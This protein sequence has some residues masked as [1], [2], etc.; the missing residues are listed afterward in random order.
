MQT[1]I[2]HDELARFCARALEAR[3]MTSADARTVA[4]VLAWAD[5][6]GIDSH[7]I[8][9]LPRYVQFMDD[10]AIDPAAQP[11]VERPGPGR[12]TV[13]GRFA[14]GAVAMMRAAEAAADTADRDGHCIAAV[15]DTTHT[16]P[17]GRYATWLAGR[18]C[19]AVVFVAGPPLMAYHGARVPSLS[20]S[21][22][23]I[24]VP[25]HEGEPLLLDMATSVVSFG[26]LRQARAKAETIPEGWALDAQGRPTT[27]G[28]QA[29]TPLP[30]GGPKGS[31]LS[32][33]I[34]MLC[35]VLLGSPILADFLAPAGR[36]RHKQNALLFAL[37]VDAFRSAAGFAADAAELTALIK[38]LPRAEGADEIRLP[39]ERGQRTLRE[40]RASG[41]P[42]PPPLLKELDAL[43][44]RFG[45]HPLSKE[46]TA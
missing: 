16:G 26:R 4:D 25:L 10:G 35:S 30:V 23:T 7:G 22:I 37:K 1:R 19:A 14:H 29:A 17:V 15:H 20:T 12:V 44:Q 8:A 38:G 28:T 13:D 21:P 18:G 6:R 41:I 40:R 27:D 43:A 5:L 11:V 45:V 33:M 24:A 2:H 31:G 32:L 46:K 34:E 3:G 42:V 9:W 39:G 36:K